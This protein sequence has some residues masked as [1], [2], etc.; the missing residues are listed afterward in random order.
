VRPAVSGL[1]LAGMVG[2]S[3]PAAGCGGSSGGKVAQIIASATG[4]IGSSNT[5]GS[6]DP[7]S[8]SACMRSHRVTNFPD[9]D[10]QGPIRLTPHRDVLGCLSGVV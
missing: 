4:N 2:L 3:L 5:L 1:G 10:S 8:C 9:P 6:R 7:L